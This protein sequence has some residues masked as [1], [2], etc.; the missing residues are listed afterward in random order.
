MT[1]TWSLT[2]T[3]NAALP[4]G[5]QVAFAPPTLTLKPGGTKASGPRGTTYPDW[6]Y[7]LATLT[8]PNATAAQTFQA[9]LHLGNTTQSLT[10]NVDGPEKRAPVAGPL[11]K[12][13][14]HYDGHFRDS[15]AR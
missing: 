7:A 1:G 6:G 2:G 11:S 10:L 5:W 12:V 8:I 4:E 14:V 15:G 3:G 9:V 13:N